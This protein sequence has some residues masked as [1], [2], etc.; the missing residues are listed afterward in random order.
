MKIPG[1]TAE[2]S[3]YRTGNTYE[4]AYETLAGNASAVVIPQ[5]CRCVRWVCPPRPGRCS[6]TERCCGAVLPDGTCDGQCWP[7][8]RPCP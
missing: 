1:F 3:V 6:S 2:A 8:S 7:R 5:Q 4:A